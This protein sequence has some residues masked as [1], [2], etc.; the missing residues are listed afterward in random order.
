MLHACVPSFQIIWPGVWNTTPRWPGAT[1]AV[2]GGT[3]PFWGGLPSTVVATVMAVKGMGW[4]PWFA[5]YT[6]TL[7]DSPGF[8][9]CGVASNTMLPGSSAL[10]VPDFTA[11]PAESS[12]PT[13]PALAAAFASVRPGTKLLTGPA[14]VQSSA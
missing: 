14:P 8:G 3:G 2:A 13:R 9:T 4:L 5:R 7:N 12:K 10:C 1:V 6:T 11:T